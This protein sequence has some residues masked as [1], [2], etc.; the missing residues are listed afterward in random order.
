[1]NR[2]AAIFVLVLLVQTAVLAAP[3]QNP[4]SMYSRALL[5]ISEKKFD[6]AL[7]L[8]KEIENSKSLENRRHHVLYQ[9]AVCYYNLEK[10]DTAQEYAEKSIDLEYT[11]DQPYLLLFNMYNE[12]SKFDESA[13]FLHSLVEIKP[14][15]Y[16][17]N[18]TL[19]V[20]YAEYIKNSALSISSLERVIEI[21]QKTAV[22]S[23]ILENTY[24]YLANLYMVEGDF[25][26]AI[27]AGGKSVRLN[28][29][30]NMR[31]YT[32]ANFFISKNMLGEA[33]KTVNLFLQNLTEDQKQNEFLYRVYA[34]MGRM[35][36]LQ[37]NPDALNYL[38]RG[39]RDTGEDGKISRILFE[40]MTRDTE[41]VRQKIRNEVDGDLKFVSVHYAMAQILEK[42]NKP[43]EAYDYYIST[44]LLLYDSGMDETARRMLSKG[45]KIKP[46]VPK[47]HEMIAG[48]YERRKSY[49][50][51][52]YHYKKSDPQGT[53]AQNKLHVAYLYYMKDDYRNARLMLNE[54]RKL[55][56]E[57]PRV[58]FTDGI[59]SS[60][61]E[62][63]TN[64]IDSY[65][66]AI[67]LDD[68]NA[69]YYFYL[70]LSQEKAKLGDDA[71]KSLEKAV[72]LD[73]ENSEYLNYLGYTYA[74][75]GMKLDYSYELIQRA[76]D[77]SP[78][79]GAY[80]DSM[81]WVHY[82]RGEYR[83]AERF[84]VRAYRNLEADNNYDP[85]VYD[86]L[87]DTYL[88]LKKNTRAIHFWELALKHGA[89]NAKIKQK[90]SLAK[91]G[92][93]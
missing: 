42:E 47:V 55:E 52:I 31:L 21:S 9:M 2:I 65:K 27:E 63:Y 56:T 35:Y 69:S 75:R 64:A 48:I 68:T 45:L 86:H 76:I 30:N 44:S 24:I 18:F 62:K 37:D 15:S 73:S 88:K 51:A 79:N 14:E 87:G 29:K 82:R 67:A 39:A 50:T 70:A 23:Q 91:K 17:Y 25:D 5:L 72:E 81:G 93:Q 22:P 12:Q 60:A 33:I 85:V 43:A 58:H 26:K 7:T 83:D 92:D 32:M 59:L 77:Q 11:Y 53:D 19:G 38:R 78:F 10:I 28:P 41:E 90:I 13:Y 84:L 34:F 1:M 3:E 74:D 80:L 71:L 61:E 8:L 89:D 4:E 6:N 46:E 20:M 36:F 49:S 66:K 57:T 16:E 40:Y 54:V